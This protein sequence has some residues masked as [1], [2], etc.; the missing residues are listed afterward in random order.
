MNLLVSLLSP[1]FACL[2]GSFGSLWS[3]L[4]VRCSKATAVGP[5][6]APAWLGFGHAYAAQD[7]TDQAM[8]AY[9]TA[10][11]IFTGCHLPLLCIGSEYQ[12]SNNTPLAQHFLDDAKSICP[13]G[14]LVHNELGV[15]AFH[16]KQLSEAE[17][18]FEAA[19]AALATPSSATWEPILVNLAHVYRKQRKLPAAIAM[20]ERALSVAPRTASTFTAIG[21]SWHLQ[22]NTGNAIEWYHKALSIRPDD[23]LASEMLGVA[24]AEEADNHTRIS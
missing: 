17:A 11:R 21:F 5:T 9:R 20:Y 12:R 15:V 6:F 16:N 7:E 19:L 13:N 22:G 2:C 3:V 14:P 1:P 4:L 18:Y 23:F 10:A 8:V 24:V